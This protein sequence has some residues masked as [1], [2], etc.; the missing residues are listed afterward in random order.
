MAEEVDARQL[1]VPVL[2]AIRLLL[3]ERLRERMVARAIVLRHEIEVLVLGRMRRP[4]ERR[5]PR[6]GDR[7][8]WEP[9]NEIRVVRRVDLEIVE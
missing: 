3:I 9:G 8:G 2:D 5:L 1:L 4:L 6:I 7:R